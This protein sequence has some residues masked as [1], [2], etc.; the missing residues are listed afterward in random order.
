M[1]R[2]VDKEKEELMKVERMAGMKARG[3]EMEDKDEDED[4]DED[5]DEG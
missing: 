4:E 2:E 3:G 5:K 1:I